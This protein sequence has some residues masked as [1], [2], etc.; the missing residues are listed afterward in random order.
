MTQTNTQINPLTAVKTGMH[1]YD[2]YQRDMGHIA[3]I[4][5]NGLASSDTAQVSPHAIPTISG[6]FFDDHRLPELLVVR[7]GRTGFFC[8]TPSDE[9]VQVR[10]YITPQQ[11]LRVRDAA[12]YLKVPADVVIRY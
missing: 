2:M 4:T 11:I 7:L 12:V 3:S 8:V 9:T 10:Y 5:L 6:M 1:V